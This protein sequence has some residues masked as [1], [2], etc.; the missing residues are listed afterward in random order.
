MSGLLSLEYTHNQSIM[1][2]KFL[3]FRIVFDVINML[4]G[5]WIFVLFILFNPEAKGIFCGKTSTKDETEMRMNVLE[6]KDLL[7]NEN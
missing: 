3:F 1:V 5:V 2:I 6:D 4:Q 7:Q